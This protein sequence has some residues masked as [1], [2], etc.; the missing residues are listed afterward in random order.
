M[1]VTIPIPD[2]FAARFGSEAELGR[3]AL[4][5]LALEE[6][7][8]RRMTP[9][10][11]QQVLGFSKGSEFDGFLRQHGLA[12]MTESESEEERKTAADELVERFKAFRAGKTLGGLNIKDLIA[13]GRR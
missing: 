7:R 11:L 10:E 9:A 6:Y 5:A 1:N 2:D 12:W 3:R 4:E 13:E 8:G